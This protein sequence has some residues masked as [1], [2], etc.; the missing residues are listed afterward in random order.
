[1]REAVIT[2]ARDASALKEEIVTMRERVRSAHPG[3]QRH[4]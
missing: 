1:M 3:A 2:S 4:V